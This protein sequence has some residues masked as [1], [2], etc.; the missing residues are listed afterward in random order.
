[1]VISTERLQREVDEVFDI[2]L[3]SNHRAFPLSESVNLYCVIMII[4]ESKYP[5]FS[6]RFYLHLFP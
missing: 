6:M 4:D 5:N 3:E 2:V 1:M